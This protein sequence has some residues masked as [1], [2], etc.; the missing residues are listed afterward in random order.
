MKAYNSVDPEQEEQGMF[1]SNANWMSEKIV[2][3]LGLESEWRK[4]KSTFY[5]K[6]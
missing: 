5:A 3:L 1:N 2:L 4:G 6:R